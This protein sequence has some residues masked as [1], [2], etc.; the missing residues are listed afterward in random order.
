[1]LARLSLAGE[2]VSTRRVVGGS[3][4]DLFG[5]AFDVMKAIS[6]TDAAV[7]I[8]GRLSGLSAT[9]GT[10][11]HEVS[12]DMGQFFAEDQGATGDGFRRPLPRQRVSRMDTFLEA[13][14]LI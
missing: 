4:W 2:L 7:F 3:E 9:F 11:P 6:T 12:Y 14:D 13:A 5:G 1:M 8:V 10:P